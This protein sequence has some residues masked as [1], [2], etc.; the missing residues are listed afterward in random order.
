MF[1]EKV[2]TVYIKFNHFDYALFLPY[3]SVIINCMY[4]DGRFPRLIT[5]CQMKEVHEA[6]DHRL[7][8]VSDISADLQVSY[9][10][11]SHTIIIYCRDR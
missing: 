8:G 2:S 6:G 1:G 11:L 4:W 5:T 3:T 7:L 10:L 9:L